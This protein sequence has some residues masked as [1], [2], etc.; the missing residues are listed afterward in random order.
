MRARASD[1]AKHGVR[2]RSDEMMLAPAVA[3]DAFYCYGDAFALG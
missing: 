3:L 2:E 1:V